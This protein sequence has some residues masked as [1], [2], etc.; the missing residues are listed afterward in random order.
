MAI[1]SVPHYRHNDT[2]IFRQNQGTRATVCP[3][4]PCTVYKEAGAVPLLIGLEDSPQQSR[5]FTS[6][7]G[8]RQRQVFWQRKRL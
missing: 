4:L 6:V 1:A 8:G 3:S 5:Q 2:L 7:G